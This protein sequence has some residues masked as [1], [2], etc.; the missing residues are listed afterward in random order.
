LL[1]QQTGCAVQSEPTPP[2]MTEMGLQVTPTWPVR[3]F[4]LAP[5]RAKSEEIPGASAFWTELPM[6]GVE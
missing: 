4:T 3:P 2:P 1:L 5:T 6:C